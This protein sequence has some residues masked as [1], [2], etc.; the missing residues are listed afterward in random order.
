MSCLLNRFFALATGVVLLVGTAGAVEV[1][2]GPGLDKY[3]T[4]LYRVEVWNGGQW[5]DSYT[6][7]VARKSVTNWHRNAVP[8]VNFTTFG[9]S[10]AVNVRIS[11]LAG[12]ITSVEI[13]PKSKKIAAMIIDGRATF[14]LKPYDKAWVTIDG[15]DANPLLVFADPPKP[16]APS[17]ALYYGPGVHDIGLEKA[18]ADGQTIYLDG[19]AWVIGTIDLRKRQNVKIM[20]PGVLSGEFMTGEQL[21]TAKMTHFMIFGDGSDSAPKNN[22]VEGIT[23]V[24]S[25]SYNICHGPDYIGNV[26]LL[27]PWYWSTDG[28]HMSPGRTSKLSVIENCFAFVADDIFF[29]R[30]NY[31]GNIEIRNCFVSTP[32]N[33]VFNICYWGDTLKHD[34]TMYAHDIDIKNYLGGGTEAIFKASIDGATNLGIKNMTFENIRVENDVFGRIL[35]IENR[36]YFWPDQSKR[37]ETKL[38]NT[39]N[40]VFRN[41]TVTGTQ[42]MKS[43]LLGLDAN[44]GHHDFLFENVTI[45]GVTLDSSNY[46]KYFDI[47]QYSWNI[48]FAA[49]S[50]GQ[51][52]Y[53]EPHRAEHPSP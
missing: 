17:G 3:K 18:P 36:N 8:S 45:N 14:T 23:I 1:Y 41:I 7:K 50:P 42:G 5:L 35:L 38:G 24:N 29:P 34:Y 4:N 11:K 49:G 51:V 20:G 33:S 22:R 39:Y 43:T 48:R 52:N 47:N 10:G 46:Q 28:F 13:S 26:K 2:P 32:N 15:D 31:K 12:K 25:P 16:V 40:L 21:H 30:Y 6:Y 44:N 19:G 37:P 27:S 9:T 53:K